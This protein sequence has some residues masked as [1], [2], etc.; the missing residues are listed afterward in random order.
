MWQSWLYSIQLIFKYFKQKLFYDIALKLIINNSATAI[1]VIYKVGT[2]DV[3]NP[4]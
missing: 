2:V 4:F 1:F 3:K